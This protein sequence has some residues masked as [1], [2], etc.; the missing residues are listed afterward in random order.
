MELEVKTTILFPTDLHKRLREVAKQRK[1]SLGQLVR[2]ACETQYAQPSAEERLRA[3]E[4]LCGLSLPVGTV[5][6]M[7]RESVPYP[8]E[9][10]PL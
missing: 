7:K 4:A 9:P 10:P 2:T 6:E 8:E 1:V 3:V 5:A